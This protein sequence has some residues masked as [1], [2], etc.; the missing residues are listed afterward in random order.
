MKDPIEKFYDALSKQIQAK[1]R[2]KELTQGVVAKAL[3]LSRPTLAN[4]E[5]GDHRLLAHHLL[6]LC[7]LL[8]LDIQEITNQYRSFKM[9][10][11]MKKLPTSIL[12]ALRNIKD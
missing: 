11:E 6:E 2:E 1:R 4:L 9:E 12:D 5:N 3:G 7:I 10:K 8:D